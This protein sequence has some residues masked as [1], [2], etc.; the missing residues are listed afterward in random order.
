MAIV[1]LSLAPRALNVPSIPSS[2]RVGPLMMDKIA[3]PPVDEE[4]P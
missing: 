1:A 3:H 4:A 2:F